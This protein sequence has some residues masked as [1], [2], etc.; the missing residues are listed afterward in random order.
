MLAV[1]NLSV[2]FRGRSG[3]NQA[4]KGIS[5]AIYPGEIVAVVGES[6]SGKS[7]TSLAVMGLL[8]SSSGRIDRG[9]MQ[10]RDRRGEV[11][12]LETLDDSQRRTLRG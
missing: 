3:E 11:H 6:G 9:S 2:S 10:F 1:Q 12:A 5:F 4:L 8:A 7:V